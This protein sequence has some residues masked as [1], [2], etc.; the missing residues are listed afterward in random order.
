MI[1]ITAAGI[2]KWIFQIE[3]MKG[4]AT[5]KSKY[6]HSVRAER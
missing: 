1:L 6:M 4:K 2:P 5:T 3:S